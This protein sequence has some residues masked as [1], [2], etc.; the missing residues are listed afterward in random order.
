MAKRRKR[1]YEQEYLYHVSV[2]D[3]SVRVE[4]NDYAYINAQDNAEFEES[5]YMVLECRLTDTNSKKCEK[6]MAVRFAIHEKEHWPNQQ[7]DKKE[8]RPIG[9]MTK[10]KAEPEIYPEETL[11]CWVVV[12]PKSYNNIQN[13]LSYKGQA[14]VM[15][16]GSDLSYRKGHIYYFDFLKLSPRTLV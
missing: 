15:F 10:M 14:K 1:N 5:I 7:Y 9:A 4:F 8:L 3:W 12:P 11:S 6:N 2:L 13:Y 16:M